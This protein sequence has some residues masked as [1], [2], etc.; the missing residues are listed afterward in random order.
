MNPQPPAAKKIEEAAALLRQ[1]GLVAMPTETVY[2]LAGDALNPTSLA[3]IFEVKQRPSFD[4]LICHAASTAMA[5]DLVSAFPEPARLLA[6]RFWP[7]PL[8]LVLPKKRRVP[9]LATSGLP[10][11]A[12]RV[13]AHRWAHQLLEAFDGPLAAPSA[14]M[15]GRISPTTAEAVR[16]ELGEQVDLILD[17]GPCTIGLESTVVGFSETG[18]PRVLRTGGIGVEE[19]EGVLGEVEVATASSSRPAAPG[20]LESHYAPRKPLH[21][22]ESDESLPPEPNIALLYLGKVSFAETLAAARCLSPTRELREAA[23][24]LFRMLRELDEHPD[25]KTIYARPV[26]NIGLGRAINDRLKR[27]AS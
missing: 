7:G 1:G 5:E 2:G 14:N 4:P 12:V 3:K 26:P 9:D 25:V 20:Q 23:A 6:Q 24:N 22:L 17:G 18:A 8:T 10:H 11:V 15:F 16:Q 27:A 21:L 13:P 19:I